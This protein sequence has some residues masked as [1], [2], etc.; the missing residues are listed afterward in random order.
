MIV[1]YA[2][3]WRVLSFIMLA[4]YAIRK[5]APN[6]SHLPFADKTAHSEK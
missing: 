6:S 5:P 3:V 1:H 4:A 2:T